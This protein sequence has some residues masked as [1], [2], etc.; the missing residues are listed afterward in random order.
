MQTLILYLVTALVF[1]GL[2]AI[3]LKTVMRPLFEGHI[4]DMLAT[5]LRLVPAALFYLAYVAGVLWFVSFPALREGA[6]LTA[7][8]AGAALG[9]MAYGTYEFTNYATLRDWHW[10]MVLVDVTWG[11]V[12]TG[13]SACAGVIAARALG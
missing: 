3:M 10:Q 12:L 8:L 7:L 6:P 2:D 4:G 9:A 13:V 1:L 11:A 5:E